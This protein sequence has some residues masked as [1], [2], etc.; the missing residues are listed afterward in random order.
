MVCLCYT[1]GSK[2]AK[3]IPGWEFPALRVTPGWGGGQNS[4]AMSKS[5]PRSS[6][7]RRNRGAD[8][9][10]ALQEAKA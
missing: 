6:T 2:K 10:C 5:W 9:V 1:S 3:A 4:E 8:T 7:E